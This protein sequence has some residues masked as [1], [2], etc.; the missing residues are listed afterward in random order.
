M[1][2]PGWGGVEFVDKGTYLG[3]LF[4]RNVSSIDVCRGAL[5]KFTHRLDSMRHALGRMSLHERIL[6][7]NV[8]LLP[9]FYYLAQFIVLP[10]WAVV[11]AAREA[12]QWGVR[13][14]PPHL[15]A[16]YLFRPT[17]PAQG[18]LGHEHDLPGLGV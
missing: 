17:H 14:R 9:L 4:G 1:L 12:A 5:D 7:F 6:L 2:T 11:V 16:G 3:V 18:P 15:P 8:F 10:Y 13:L